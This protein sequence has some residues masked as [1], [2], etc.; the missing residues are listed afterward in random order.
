MP[1]K[2]WPL[3][4]PRFFNEERIQAPARNDQTVNDKEV[5]LETTLTL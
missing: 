2:F 1:R 4:S 5:E 3:A